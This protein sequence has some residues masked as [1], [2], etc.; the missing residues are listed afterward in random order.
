MSAYAVMCRVWLAARK[1]TRS[2][3]M[4]ARG[5]P[6]GW[7]VPLPQKRVVWGN[8]PSYLGRILLVKPWDPR[9]RLV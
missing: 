4:M 1:V 3:P 6:A 2:L 7:F 5:T 9:D 8:R